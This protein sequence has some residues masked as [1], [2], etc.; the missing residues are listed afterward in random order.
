MPIYE[1]RCTSCDVVIEV[2]QSIR[3]RRK[4][5]CESCGGKLEKMISRTSF[6]LKGGGWYNEGYGSKSKS[7]DSKPEKSEPSKKSG[8]DT[9][10]KKKDNK[11]SSSS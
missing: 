7:D 3:E 5:K 6:Q 2:M 8:S 1:Y 10:K 4:T 11:G 9:K